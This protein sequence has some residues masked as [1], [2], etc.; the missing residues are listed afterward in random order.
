MEALNIIQQM[1]RG[2]MYRTE[3]P[4]KSNTEGLTKKEIKEAKHYEK[5][6]PTSTLPISKPVKKCV[7][8]LI[9]HQLSKTLPDRYNK[10]PGKEGMP[11]YVDSLL[12][13]YCKNV[14]EIKI[15]WRSLHV[16]NEKGEKKGYKFVAHEFI[17][18]KHD[19]QFLD[20]EVLMALLPNV[21][22]I[23]VDNLNLSQHTMEAI[24]GYTKARQK[25]EEEEE[26]FNK[27]DS[28]GLESDGTGTGE[29][30]KEAE[31]VIATEEE[32]A[33]QVLEEE[34]VVVAKRDDSKEEEFADHLEIKQPEEEVVR[35]QMIRR[36]VDVDSPKEVVE[37][38]FDAKGLDL[39]EIIIYRPTKEAGWAEDDDNGKAEVDA[40]GDKNADKNSIDQAID[41]FK[42]DLGKFGWNMEKKARFELVIS[43]DMIN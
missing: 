12:N 43:K 33:G 8:L 23:T 29:E 2:D 30:N 9:H 6:Y 34:V 14:D 7:Q 31:I 22:K 3:P 42:D 5:Y 39:R 25:R 15:D 17:S 40:N 20:L 4:K 41:K 24:S 13:F 18:K 19:G 35:E 10:Y 32:E 16:A 37:E 11:E 1:F 36:R 28:A 21:K 38:E 26:L 27:Q